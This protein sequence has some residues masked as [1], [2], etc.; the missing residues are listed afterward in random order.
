MLFIPRLSVILVLTFGPA[1]DIQHAAKCTVAS[2]LAINSVFQICQAHIFIFNAK[3][4][5]LSSLQVREVFANK[6][7]MH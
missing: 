2:S 4:F 1:L 3:H 7:D 6:L 5:Y